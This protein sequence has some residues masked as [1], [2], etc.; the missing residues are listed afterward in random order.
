MTWLTQIADRYQAAGALAQGTVELHAVSDEA[1]ANL[2][3]ALKR[4]VIQLREEDPEIWQELLAVARQLRW[5]L[6]TGD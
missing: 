6:A 4:L 1:G 3:A 5:R 2:D